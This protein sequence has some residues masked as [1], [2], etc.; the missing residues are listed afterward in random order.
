[1]AE[2]LAKDPIALEFAGFWRRF[3]AYIIDAFVIGAFSAFLEPLFWPDIG[4]LLEFPSEFSTTIW[5][6]QF[7]A[8][9]NLASF[10]MSGIYF[11]LFWVWRGQTLGMM[12]LGMKVIRVDGSALD[13]GRAIA[14]YAGYLVS[15]IP[16]FLGF[17]WIAFDARKQGWHDKIADTVVVKL[18]PP[19]EVNHAAPPTAVA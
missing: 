2:S 3:G 15:I 16:L 9:S 19:V 14:R 8:L 1:M 10:I 6:A 5:T 11:V 13:L 4:N 18:P 12:A 17:I 7:E